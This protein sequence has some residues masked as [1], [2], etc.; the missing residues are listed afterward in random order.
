MTQRIDTPSSATVSLL[1]TDIVGSTRLLEEL[2]DDYATLLS[3]HHR[4]LDEA[5]AAH[6]GARVD[7][8]GDGLFAS[9]PTARAALLACIDAQRALA[10]HTWPR[11]SKVEVRM[12][13]HTGEPIGSGTGYVGIDV[14]RAARI[15]AA[16][17]GGQILVSDSARAL[18]GSAVPDTVSFLDLGEHRLKDLATAIR[19]HQVIAPGL[20]S[21]FPPVR[22]L[23]TLPNNLPRQLSTFVGRSQEI[24][25]VVE[26]LSTTSL[27]TLT[28][29]GGVGKT[30][31]ALE[32]G[33][34][35][36]DS[37]PD[38]AWFAEFAAL[39]D[40]A[41]V[42]DTVA[43]ALRVK[44][45]ADGPL[46]A[47]AAVLAEQHALLIFDNCEHVLDAVVSLADT[48]LRR[49]PDVRILVTS[50]EALGMAGESLMPVPSMSLPDAAATAT[51]EELERL[52][53]SD[54]VRLFLDRG[55]AVDPGF[56]LTGENAEAVVQVCRRL[57]GIP[58]AIELA[59][60]RLRSLPPAQIAARLDQRFRLL[61]GGS[62]T[63]LP[64]H[65]TLRAA[66]DWSIDLLPEAERVLVHRLATF[67]GSF[68]LEA[69]EAVAS[70]GP[71]EADEMID[72]LAHL[73]DKSLLMPEPTPT[74]AR[75]RMLETIRDYAQ[76]RL[77]ESDEA[78]EMHARHRD[79]FVSLVDQARPGFF[80]GAEQAGW[81]TRLSDELDNLRAALQWSHDDP[82]GASTELGLA[83]GLWRF[84]E[85]RGHLAEGS[86]W[87]SRALERSGG[88]VSAR[89]ASA[90]TGAGVLASHRGDH[91]AAVAFHEASLLVHRELGDPLSIAAACS[92]VA[93]IAI[94]LG[95]VDRARALYL[96]AIA[97]AEAAGDQRGAAFS[98]VNLADVIARH[99]DSVEAD[100]LYARAVGIF[101]SLGDTW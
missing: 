26:R 94:E 31:L 29:P 90:L 3:D 58:L 43:S 88:E 79:W 87:L 37:Y 62:R 63:A 56:R 70:G 52:S 9:F 46:P 44:P 78:A 41:L 30:R 45:H 20:G 72:L 50:R 64:R 34:H 5:L 11:G 66:M 54:S 93:S 86:A 28:G 38:G 77:A 13:L 23:E 92:N 21:E 101:E 69:A 12:G 80:S 83:S 98:C 49:C 14:H 71:V 35:V 67:S 60:A 19:L 82:D 89:R 100:A 99:G 24:D 95:D 57:D 42:P 33:A 59:A 36:V 81:L 27:L 10:A 22:S 68:S 39:D 75:Y 48:L 15:C 6:G 17:H 51:P 74:E 73:I 55:Q 1:F 76:E 16:G 47:L 8:A 61:T 18:I 2:G 84:W 25:D 32:V 40:P 65:R 53:A 91:R 4:I 85:I 96:E 7:A 97:S